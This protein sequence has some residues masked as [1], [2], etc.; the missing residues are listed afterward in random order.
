MVKEKS[1]AEQKMDYAVELLKADPFVAT[2]QVNEQIEKKFGNS[3][4]AIAIS[5]LRAKL[6]GFTFAGRGGFRDRKGKKVDEA[7]IRSR[8]GLPTT[9]TLSGTSE[10]DVQA[11]GTSSDLAFTQ[12]V[13]G[14][15]TGHV[16]SLRAEMV[17][18][19]IEALSIPAH[20]KFSVNYLTRKSVE[21]G[22]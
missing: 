9:A 16:N 20:G 19:G 2:K 12:D 3:V 6:H 22:E 1:K 14:R 8:L 15:I 17:K 13:I 4:Q 21:L 18:V 7:T 11:G 10:N 5:Q